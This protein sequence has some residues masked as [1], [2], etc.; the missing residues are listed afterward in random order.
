MFHENQ[1]NRISLYLIKITFL[2]IKISRKKLITLILSLNMTL[3][4]IINYEI[5]SL[6]WMD[7][8]CVS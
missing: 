5:F 7:E 2:I 4:I 3:F 1:L 8:M 6:Q